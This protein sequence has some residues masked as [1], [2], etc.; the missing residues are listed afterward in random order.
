MSFPGTILPALKGDA[1]ELDELVIRY[2]LK[3][4]YKYLWLAI[5]RLT[6]QVIGFT[7]GDRSTKSLQRLW[8]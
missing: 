3:R 6:R 4:R 2:R 5:S 8:F 7:I 1:L